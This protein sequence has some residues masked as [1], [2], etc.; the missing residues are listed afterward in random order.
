MTIASSA[1]VHPSAVIE[2]GAVIGP[3]CRIGPF[4]VVGPDVDAG[5]WRRAEIPCR[6]H[7]LDLHRGGHR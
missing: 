1:Q 4:C 7:R 6:R 3:D 2:D 5:P